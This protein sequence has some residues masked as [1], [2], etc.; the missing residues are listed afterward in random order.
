MVGII[1]VHVLIVSK[2]VN[3]VCAEI[4]VKCLHLIYYLSLR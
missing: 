4:N 1:V 2:G 3:L